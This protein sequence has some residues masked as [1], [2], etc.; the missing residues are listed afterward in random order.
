MAADLWFDIAIVIV[1]L[2][3]SAF[4][5]GAETAITASSRARMH[6]LELNGDKNAAIVIS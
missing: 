1:S 3:L 4:F 2:V 6:A 5:A